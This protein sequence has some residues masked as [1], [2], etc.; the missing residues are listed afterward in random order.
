MSGI[1]GTSGN[2]NLN[3]GSGDDV[4]SGG[5][6][7]DTMS[8]GSGND[9][10]DG[11]SGSDRLNGGSGDDVLVYRLA[12]N[13]GTNDIYTGG[14]GL[15]TIRLQLTSAEWL[16]ADVQAQIAQ[17]IQHLAAVKTNKNTG[18]VSNGSASDFTFVFNG[19]SRLTVQMMERLDVWVDGQPFDFRAPFI[20]VADG[21]GAVTEDAAAPNLSDSGTIAFGDVEW[22]QSHSASVAPGSGN[23]LGGTLAA[24]VTNSA[25]GDGAGVVTWNYS[26]PNSATQHLS[27]GQTAV[28]RSRSRSRTAPA[29]RCSSRSR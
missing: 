18:E 10:M 22:S 23:A 5:A 21:A 7:N 29:R 28:R 3:G 1:T 8:G 13:G 9:L 19:N 11:G 27:A 14:S 24:S 6:G 15:D 26:V 17:Y 12:E 25:T 2:D 20:T 4:M 16:R